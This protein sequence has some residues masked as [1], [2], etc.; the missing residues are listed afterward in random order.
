MNWFR[1]V[2]AV[3]SKDLLVERRSPARISGLFFF[4]LA[5]LLLVA[6]A[7]GGSSF[8]LPQI[9][10]ATLGVGLL[11]ASTRALDQSWASELERGALE[12]LVLWPVSPSALFYGKALANTVVLLIVLAVLCPLTLAI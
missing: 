5:L 10:G 1:Q 3:F 4:A 8:L 9:A 2:W 6:Y 7:N 11:L 12:G